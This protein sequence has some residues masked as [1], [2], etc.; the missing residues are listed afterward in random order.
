MNTT[1]KSIVLSAFCLLAAS[2]FA[3][4]PISVFSVYVTEGAAQE[5]IPLTNAIARVKAAGIT[6]LDIDVDEIP[7]VRP[8]LDAGLKA[9]NV[10]GFVRF[11]TPDHGRA[12]GDR[13]I[14]AAKSVGAPRVMVLPDDLPDDCAEEDALAKIIAG[15]APFV[16]RAK[17]AGLV[18]TLEDFGSP[19]SP[20]ARIAPMKKMLD[21]IP[22]LRLTLDSG[23]F[24]YA[25]NGDGDDVMEAFR[26]F[27]DRIVHAHVK[28]YR[29]AKP[30]T[31]TPLG[32]GD[33]PNEKL[34]KALR[35]SGYSGS[36]TIEESAAPDYIVA[37][38]N[39]AKRLHAWQR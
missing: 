24:H 4:G 2:L 30:R 38:E 12:E 35:A 32:E 36:I 15:L 22:D 29:N 19:K 17:A 9:V 7:T 31:Y 14:A 34:V 20:C 16:E 27:R 6:G 23:N 1:F 39:A 28:D 33:I 37:V 8:M 5:K 13:L 18:V 3:E 11:L 25:G 26:L 10:Y 21:A